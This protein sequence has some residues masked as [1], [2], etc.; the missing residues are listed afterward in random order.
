[1]NWKIILILT[2]VSA[3][4]VVITITSAQAATAPLSVVRQAIAAGNAK[5]LKSLESGDAK[6]F[7]AQ[8]APDGIEL[9]SGGTG[10]TTGRSAI[11]AAVTGGTRITSGNIHT[12]NVYLEGGVAYET[13]TYAFDFA[14]PGKPARLSTGRYFEVW[15]RQPDGSWLIKVDC[16]YP[17]KYKR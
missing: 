13:G 3:F 8:F 10:V 7:A 12:T 9:A 1:V 2:L 5:F 11:Q 16:G 14:V 17:D 15:E 4:A 6:T